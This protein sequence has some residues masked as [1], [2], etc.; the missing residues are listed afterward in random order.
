MLGAILA[1]TDPVLA[2]DVGVGP[3]GRART[4]SEP[5]FAP[6]T[7]EAGLNDGLAFPFVFAGLF[8]ARP[9]RDRLDR[10]VGARRRPLRDRR[11]RRLGAAVGYGFAALA[12]RLRDRDLLAP[13][14]RLARDPAVLLIYGADR[15]RRRLRL[16]RRVRRRA[17]V[18]ALRARPRA[19]RRRSTRAPRWSRSSASSR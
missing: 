12:V 11:R 15:G 10:R 18:P 14:R 6:L 4:S 17:R 16:P 1:P 8:V 5:S 13:L 19:Q 2:G 3:P 7:A 9:G